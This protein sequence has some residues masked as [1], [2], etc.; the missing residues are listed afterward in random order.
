MIKQRII[1]S[2]V[3]VALLLCTVLVLFACSGSDIDM[4]GPGN[5]GGGDVSDGITITFVDGEETIHT[6]KNPKDAM[7]YVPEEKE[8]YTFEGWFL[9]EELTEELSKSPTKSTTLYAKWAIKTFTVRFV[10]NDGSIIQVNGE[11]YQVIEY[12][13][14]AIAPEDPTLEGHEFI[15]WSVP[16][17][18]VKSDLVVRADFGTAKQSIIVYGEDGNVILS[19][20]AE[21]GSDITVRYNTLLDEVGQALPG[22]LALEALCIDEELTTVYN[23]PESG[24]TMPTT[25]LVL[26][27]RAVMQDIEGLSISPSRSDYRYDTKGVTLTSSLYT[28]AIITYSYEW[29]DVNLDAVIEGENKSILNVP[30]KDVG[31]YVYEVRV[32]ATYKDDEPKYATKRVTITVT[33]GTLEG[34]ISAEGYEDVYNGLEREPNFTGRLAGDVVTY[35]RVGASTYGANPI[36]NAGDYNVEMKVERKNYE[37]LELESVLVKITKAELTL[38]V[39]LPISRVEYGYYVIFYGSPVPYIDYEFEGF[40]NDETEEDLEGQ[41]SAIR[42]NPYYVGATVGKYELGLKKDCWTPTNYVIKNWPVAKLEVRKRSLTITVDE[43]QI[44]YGD[45]APKYTATLEGAIAEDVNTIKD[46]IKFT[47]GYDKA[48]DQ[49]NDVLFDRDGNVIGYA[50]EASLSHDSYNVKVVPSILKVTQ[51]TVLVT[52]KNVTLTYGD[53]V[54]SYGI[55]V[56]G[57]IEG[58]SIG[59]PQGY[60]AYVFGT[61]VGNYPIS[62]RETL[63]N[64]NYTIVYG[65]GNLKV[66]PKNITVTLKESNIVYF[67]GFPTKESFASKIVVDGLI[68]KDSVET[69]ITSAQSFT[70]GYAIGQ[71]VGDYPVTVGGYYSPNYIINGNAPIVGN[72][73]V[74]PRALTVKVVD[75][76]VVYGE[77]LDVEVEY[78][79]LVGYDQFHPEEVVQKGPSISG[80]SIGTDVGAYPVKVEGYSASNYVITYEE[81]I[82]TVLP[83]T[84]TLKARGYT[85]DPVVWNGVFNS[86]D[87]ATN[88]EIDGLYAGDAVSGRISSVSNLE[89]IYVA[90][91]DAL[92]GKFVWDSENPFAI[93]RDGLNKMA[94]YKVVFD[95]QVA[96]NT[97]GVFV[98]SNSVVYDANAHG[99][100]VEYLEGF[101]GSDL[102]TIEYSTNGVD[103]GTEAIKYTSAGEYV[104]YYKL[105][106]SGEVKVAESLSLTISPRPITVQVKDKTITYGDELPTLDYETISYDENESAFANGESMANLGELTIQIANF[107]GNAGFYDIIASG[108]AS[109]NY[110]ITIVDGELVVNQK[111]LTVTAQSYAITYG[112]KLP[113]YTAT[114]EGFIE[115]ENLEILGTQVLFNCAYTADSNGKAGTFAIVPI[116][117]LENYDV[118]AVAGD[119]VVLKKAITLKANNISVSYGDVTPELDVTPSALAYND[120]KA[121]I[122]SYTLQTQYVRGSKV[123]NYEITLEATSDKYEL[124]IQK[125]IIT[126]NK[127]AVDLIWVGVKGYVYDGTDRSSAVSASYYDIDGAL[128]SATISFS[129]SNKTPNKLLNAGSYTVKATTADNNYSLKDATKAIQMDKA[130]YQDIAY[131]SAFTGVYSPEKTL[132]NDYYLEGEGYRWATPDVVPTVDVNSYKAFYNL[133]PDN[134][135]DFEITVSVELTPALISLST[136]DEQVQLVYD[137]EQQIDLN[138]TNM[139]PTYT[140][141]P[142]I[143]WIEGGKIIGSGFTISFSNGNV[144][145]PGSYLTVMTFTSTN[146]MLNTADG[147]QVI[148][149][150]I[151]YKSVLVGSTLYTPEDAL[152]KVTSGNA[153]VRANT[154]FASQQEVINRYYNGSAYYT[155]KSGTTFLLPLSA[156][157]TTG[158]LNAGEAGSSEYNAHPVGTQNADPAPILYITLNVPANVTITVN[159]TLTVGAV[160]GRQTH[161]YN[162]NNVSGNYCVINLAGNVVVNSATLN[163]YGYVLGSGKI[164]TNGSTQV[165]ENMYLSG[166][167]TGSVV[168][169]RFIG[170][171]EIMATTFLTGGTYTVDNPTMFPFNQYE[172]RS[173]QTNLE[174]NYGGNLRGVI[175]ISTSEQTALSITVAEAKINLAYMGIISSSTNEGSGIIRMTQ[176]GDKVTKSTANGRVKFT[177]DG[178]IKDGYTTFGVKVLA[179]DISLTGQKVLFPIAGTCDIVVNSG[180]FTQNYQY[181]LMPGATLTVKKGATLNSNN[182]IVTFKDGFVDV[183][184][185]VAYPQGRGDAKVIVE[186]TLN[187][188][189]AFGG[190]VYGVN[191]GKVVVGANA[192]I[193]SVKSI[194][195]TGNMVRDGLKLNFTFTES[196]SVVRNLDLFNASGSTTSASKGT[197]YT[198]NGTA[199][200]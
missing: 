46:S 56:Q 12:G 10:H 81:G 8:G 29:Y 195:G 173:I 134:Y 87:K 43:K 128:V 198:Y 78:K 51:K 75:S 18:S 90:K 31:E 84:L 35:R 178:A 170:N 26:Y 199:W 53:A 111:P 55:D 164:T 176:A 124:T 200:A 32:K 112:D 30:S 194:E 189:S 148:N 89:G 155:V 48:D 116:L 167:T 171:A 162:Q 184:G 39:T 95:L 74:N 127:K 5:G 166:W 36:K 114:T 15:G 73:K 14:P 61:N 9:D 193:T 54:P 7:S 16:F 82:I 110:A 66:N 109:E 72:L 122:G 106:R 93:I 4:S 104:I 49:K 98:Y 120:T 13:K 101:E 179:K 34:L 6:S 163:V 105:I 185:P 96:I 123:G 50:I 154:N 156:T 25:D 172:L 152:N 52:P 20:K 151:K 187:I 145:T 47:C 157:D 38:S 150:F 136:T 192:S 70:S 135:Y 33:P 144:F 83:R 88:V 129:A 149:Y 92:E 174:I 188:N 23:A 147:S 2:L 113:A 63:K 27:V 67:E 169:A 160:T 196:G 132:G 119:L 191:G 24:H 59:T 3:V 60:S 11:D 130:K 153:T 125:G 58:D 41:G 146:Y 140:L 17:D 183:V 103:Y 138:S 117:N 121:T 139:N 159:G 107:A 37:P 45:D 62:V 80:Y 28:N 108:I 182:T 143:W 42:V 168:A 186:G 65:T 131:A 79:G 40:V 137:V 181:K 142:L 19:V 97:V 1:K 197:T 57:L 22:G 126:V 100:D 71:P 91:G 85:E 190:S 44:V 115:G 94:N 99:L 161:G 180:S 165:T 76:S 141:N 21:V 102:V 133:D 64:A 158:F 118:T 175:K 177:L 69:L 68:S 77:A 86:S